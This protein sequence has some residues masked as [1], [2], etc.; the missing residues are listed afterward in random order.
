[1]TRADRFGN[2][3]ADGL[4]Y[5]RGA[6]ITSTQDDHTKLARAREFIRHRHTTGQP[7][8]NLT[9]LER[10]MPS[11]LTDAVFDDEMAPALFGE[12]LDELTLEHLGGDAT[13]DGVLVTNRLT[14][15]IYCA[16]QVMVPKGGVVV[17]VSAGYSHPAVTRAV[18]DVGGVLYDTTGLAGFA[19]QLEQLDHVDAVVLTRLAVTYEALPND[20]LPQIVALARKRGAKIF[21]DD[22]GGC[23]VGPAVLGQPR[24]LELD[25]DAGATGLDKYGT[26]G[27]RLGLLAG[28][29]ELVDAMRVRAFELGMEARA[30]LYPAVVRS[31]EQYTPER[32][33]ELVAT[34]KLVGA[35][36]RED[37]GDRVNETPVIVQLLGE[38]VLDV[39]LERSGRNDPPCVPYEATAALAM[40]LLRDHGINTVHFAGLPPG[41]SALMVKFLPPET[42]ER[43]GGPD[44]FAKSVGDSL[45]RLAQLCHDPEEIKELLLGRTPVGV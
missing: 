10:S 5:A 40:L 33:R 3:Y 19:A 16:I 45:D 44:M 32:V 18:H 29:K 7:V 13:R 35:K 43:L 38:D 11:N 24:T 27:P 28:R 30:M 15:A 26:I 6:I 36:L 31:L 37:L 25:V 8:Y 14:A 4:P 20:E 22:A 1:M 9:G 41:S 39:A 2:V 42:I 23:R 21:V 17:G 34:T 12:R